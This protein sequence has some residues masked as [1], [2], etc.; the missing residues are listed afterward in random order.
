MPEFW[1]LEQEE[2]NN[3]ENKTGNAMAMNPKLGD[4]DQVSRNKRLERYRERQ[5]RAMGRVRYG[6]RAQ[7]IANRPRVRGR[8]VKSPDSA[9]QLTSA[10]PP[11]LFDYY[12]QTISDE[13]FL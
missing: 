6:K 4:Y 10:S 12:Y 3:L 8:F 2:D 1:F 9:P 5:Q 11:L 7:A 13:D